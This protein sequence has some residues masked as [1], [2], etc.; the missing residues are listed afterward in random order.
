MVIESSSILILYDTKL[1]LLDVR[2]Y[3]CLSDVDTV[4]SIDEAK[5]NLEKLTKE[6]SLV[7]ADLAFSEYEQQK[8]F[9]EII[10]MLHIRNASIAILH[11]E[12]KV[13]NLCPE[14][15]EKADVLLPHPISDTHL[16]SVIDQC[17]QQFHHRAALSLCRPLQPIHERREPWHWCRQ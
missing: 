9:L 14:I 1:H 3:D 15:L 17:W 2:K 7:L 5:E 10:S 8:A 6:F 11:E 12:D 13:S 16:T 4:M